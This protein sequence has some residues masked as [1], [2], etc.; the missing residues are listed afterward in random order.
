MGMKTSFKL[1]VYGNTRGMK[2]FLHKNYKLLLSGI[3]AAA[4]GLCLG[5]LLG[6]NVLK[7][8]D[9]KPLSKAETT[10]TGDTKM[11][12]LVHFSACEHEMYVDMDQ[13]AYLGYTRDDL[14][15]QF[16]DASI[17]QFEASEVTLMQVNT[18]YC[19]AHYVLR[20]REDGTLGVMQTDSKFFTEELV[21]L[22]PDESADFAA[23][24]KVHLQSGIAFETLSEIDAYLE[25]VGS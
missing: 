18:G 12:R 6:R 21:A 8:G 25:N 20:L 3:I 17:V 4:A 9:Q 2:K 22:L 16:P 10:I 13:Q 15:R 19:P 5:L 7:K 1:D 14:I 11:E 24:E 23:S